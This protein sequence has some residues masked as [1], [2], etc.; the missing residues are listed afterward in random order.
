MIRREFVQR[1][2][3]LVAEDLERLLRFKDETPDSLVA[4]DLKAI[5]G[6]W[7]TRS[8]RIFVRHPGA[9]TGA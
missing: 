7:H 4:D 1:K 5:A 3:Q 6:K 8:R 2:L 9:T